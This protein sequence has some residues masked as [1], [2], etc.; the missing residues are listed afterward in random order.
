MLTL[1]LLSGAD[2]LRPLLGA[3]R[4]GHEA[5][6]MPCASH[7]GAPCAC[8]HAGRPQACSGAD[9]GWD[10]VSRP[11]AEVL[12]NESARERTAAGHLAE[13]RGEDG[14]A[15]GSGAAQQRADAS[16]SLGAEALERHMAG[17]CLRGREEVGYGVEEDGSRQGG[18][19]GGA[20]PLQTSATD[21][22][23]PAEA[24]E[25]RM[26]G[27]AGPAWAPEPELVLV[28]SPMRSD[29]WYHSAQSALCAL[30]SAT[31][32]LSASN[33]SRSVTSSAKQQQGVSVSPMRRHVWYTTPDVK[34]PHRFDVCPSVETYKSLGQTCQAWLPALPAL[35]LWPHLPLRC[36]WYR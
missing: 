8:W 18:S 16:R 26:A 9:A 25:R 35:Q 15:P 4:S 10:A 13:K 24:L 2:S 20:A 36:Q 7:D 5:P 28:W 14:R 34:A 30:S 31:L 23:G 22:L 12:A 17:E 19:V 33:C 21:P 27:A 3:A 32:R 1:R 11:A 6:G 29:D